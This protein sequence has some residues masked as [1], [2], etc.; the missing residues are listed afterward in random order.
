MAV[1]LFAFPEESED[2]FSSDA[3][4]IEGDSVDTRGEI[5]N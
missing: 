1:K 2:S 3:S 5:S 4:I